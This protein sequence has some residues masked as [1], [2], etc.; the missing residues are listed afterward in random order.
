VTEQASVASAQDPIPQYTPN[1]KFKA[2]GKEYELDDE[3]RGY[4]KTPDD[5]KRIKRLF[6]QAKAFEHVHNDREKLKGESSKYKGELD[7]YNKAI[8]QVN[9]FRAKGDFRRALDVIGFGKDDVIKA[10]KQI[11]DFDAL[12]QQAQDS[13]YQA[14][15]AERQ[16]QSLYEQNQAYANQM[17]ALSTSMKKIELSNA[18]SN[19]EIS[20]IKSRYDEVNGPGAFERAVINVGES[21]FAL[22]QQD[23]S[24]ADAVEMVVKN[25]RPFMSQQAPKPP[26]APREVPVIP[27]VKGAASASAEKGISSIDD[28]KRV[29]KEKFGF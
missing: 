13:Y 25:I 17:A 8:E 27:A 14:V 29:R 21:H 4:V 28:L 22:K 10:A 15:E 16:A 24:A 7:I 18:L 6:E 9:Q 2:A 19:P 20:E 3:Y 26:M 1:F 5:E 23:I 11:L 12:P